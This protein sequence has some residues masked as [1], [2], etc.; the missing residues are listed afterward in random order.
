LS[1]LSLYF[2]KLIRY[3]I[4]LETLSVKFFMVPLLG[5]GRGMRGEFLPLGF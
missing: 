3:K 2:A 4:P 1:K 5:V